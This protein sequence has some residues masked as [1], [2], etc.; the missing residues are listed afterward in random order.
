[1]RHLGTRTSAYVDG[2]L[3]GRQLAR[4]EAHLRQ[5]DACAAQVTAEWQVRA[6]LRSLAVA[7]PPEHLH[8]RLV[9]AATASGARRLGLR[10]LGDR[11]SLPSWRRRVA[12]RALAA[13]GVAATMLL[14]VVLLGGS[15]DVG[16][17]DILRAAGSDGA[18]FR[19]SLGPGDVDSTELT[20]E[21]L[22][23]AGWAMPELPVDLHISDVTVHREGAAEVLEVEVMG[24]TG[25]A[26]VLQ[27][28]GGL[29]A[30]ALPEGARLVQC[31][32]VAAVVSGEHTVR[33][34]VAGLLPAAAVDSSVAGR[35]DRGMTTI[36]SYLQ[37]VSP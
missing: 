8:A 26:T 30:G 24:A 27:V 2:R 3:T 10:R 23:A 14:G 25:A 13:T 15:P 17:S 6:R 31:G 7:E 35:F 32:A 29:D 18:A 9:M 20:T 21:A 37:D 5:C 19:A 1:M 4:A 22:R 33:D 11:V 28:H 36:V 12:G 34:R 16:S